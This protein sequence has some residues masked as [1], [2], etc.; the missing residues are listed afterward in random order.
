MRSGIEQNSV[1]VSRSAPNG[2]D[3]SF[4]LG[5]RDR[6]QT[7]GN[8]RLR[9]HQNINTNPNHQIINTNRPSARRNLFTINFC[10]IRG[11]SANLNSVHYHLQSAKPDILFLTETQISP[12]SICSRFDFPGYHLFP[13]LRLRGGVCCYSKSGI[14]FNIISNYT[15]TN[16]DYSFYKFSTPSSTKY[17]C[18]VYRSPNASL[19]PSLFDTLSNEINLLPIDVTSEILILGDFNIHNAEW[20]EFSARTDAV[21][22]EGE[23]FADS[24]NLTQL[25]SEPTRV[26]DS[27]D[28]TAYLLDLFLTNNPTSYAVNVSS[29]LGSSDHC[30]ISATTHLSSRPTPAE[31]VEV[32]KYDFNRADWDGLRDFYAAFPF[33]SFFSDNPSSTAEHV[34]DI[35]KI[36]MEE[37]IPH[38]TFTKKINSPKW[39]NS[40]CAIAINHKITAFKKYR[41]NKSSRT[42]NYY[43]NVRDNAKIVIKIAKSNFLNNQADRLLNNPNDNKI[44]WSTLNN[45]NCNFNKNSSIP[46]LISPNGEVIC[47]SREKANLLSTTFSSNSNIQEDDREVPRLGLGAPVISQIKINERLVKKILDNLKVDKAPGPDEIPPIVLKKCSPE[48][49]PILSKLFRLSFFSST[50]PNSWKDANIHPIPKKGDHT[51]PLNYRPISLTSTLGKTFETLL[52]SQILEHLEKHHLIHDRQYGFRQGRSTADL[53]SHL[54]HTFYQN[55]EQHGETHTVA[56]DIS[57]AFD[58][59]WHR[60]LISKLPSYG[61]TPLVPFLSSF[62]SGRRVRVA[63]DGLFSD[64]H[65]INSGVPQGSVLAPTL[66]LIHIN[67]LLSATK[68]P[69]H[70]YADDSTLHC[71]FKLQNSNNKQSVIDVARQNCVISLN[72]DLV[73]VA[74]WGSNNM[75]DFNPSKTKYTIFSNRPDIASPN[76]SFNDINIPSSPGIEVLGVALSN[77]LSWT[78]FIKSIAK[79]A[80]QKLGLLYRA[81]HYFSDEQMS[82]IYCGHVRPQMEYCCHLW[83]GGAGVSLRS[84][85]SI[86]NRAI[87]T[88]SNPSITDK[89][90]SLK[91][92]RN[93]ASLSLFYRYFNQQCSE[94][95]SSI[96]PPPRTHTRHTRESGGAH[97]NSIK[98][99]H[100]RT[101]SF[102]HSFIPRTAALWNSLPGSVFPTSYN[103]HSFKHNINKFLKRGEDVLGHMDG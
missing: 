98:I 16:F 90:P 97:A 25:V 78:P 47:N 70:S 29:P 55:T 42:L 9:D 92:R 14:A 77:N 38:K 6:H 64:F 73:R 39:F 27:L 15:S 59:V 45:F 44:F 7:T 68:N 30:L 43:K 23:L 83:S 91:H 19:A 48:L 46:N 79:K 80:A 76:I 96:I 53:L 4:S 11:L 94:E 72:S 88:I 18:C 95:L 17:I 21:G 22:V 2:S 57:K 62:L 54:T 71:S 28:H 84:L 75:V 36:G 82:V 100:T 49:A 89:Y 99:P 34:T 51:N 81:K 61:L 103:I 24:H 93:V 101:T 60:S 50:F 32:V 67:D 20:L 40:S 1:G 66:F 86:Q 13:N 58:R 37:Y 31:S 52:N 3:V 69:I 35:I 102:K 41:A 12:S 74:E 33:Y 87:K 8:A 10:N 65:S 63:L 56:L 85:D 5:S 26:P